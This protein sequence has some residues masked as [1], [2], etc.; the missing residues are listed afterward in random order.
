V[1]PGCNSA[2]VRAMGFVTGG[3]RVLGLGLGVAQVFA[4]YV[5]DEL[6]YRV[7]IGPGRVSKALVRFYLFA[8]P[9]LP[10]DQSGR[11]VARSRRDRALQ[12]EDGELAHEGDV[13]TC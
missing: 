5:L 10:R 8:T 9:V 2:R 7:L 3:R 4:D 12:G 13:P 11:L 6:G 1:P